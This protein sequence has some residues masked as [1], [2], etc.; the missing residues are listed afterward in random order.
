MVF[1]PQPLVILSEDFPLIDDSLIARI[2]DG[3]ALSNSTGYRV[4]KQDA[5][6]AFLEKHR[7]KPVFTISW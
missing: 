1:F 5:V 2:R 4:A 3:M 7:G 6:L